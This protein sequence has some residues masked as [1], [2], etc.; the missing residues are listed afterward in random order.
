MHALKPT[1]RPRRDGPRR[2]PLWWTM[3]RDSPAPFQPQGRERL[4]QHGADPGVH[5]SATESD[6]SLAFILA[7]AGDPVLPQ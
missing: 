2:R 4:Q 6:A 1:G 3:T 5:R 7:V